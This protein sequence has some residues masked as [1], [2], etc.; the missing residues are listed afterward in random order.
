MSHGKG[1]E[2]QM[3]PPLDRPRGSARGE[4]RWWRGQEAEQGRREPLDANA[5][6]ERVGEHKDRTVFLMQEGGK[7]TERTRKVA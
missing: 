5:L 7:A 4:M 1:C 2:G 6:A 3:G